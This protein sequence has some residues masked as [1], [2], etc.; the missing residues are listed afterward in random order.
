MLHYNC[1]AE[2]TA[3]KPAMLNTKWPRNLLVVA[4]HADD[5]AIGCGG[6]IA[7]AAEQGTKVTVV[8]MAAGGIRHR[9]LSE[10]CDISTRIA[11]LEACSQHLGVSQVQVL[12]KGKDMSLEAISMLE[13]VTALDHILDIGEYEEVF[14][15]QPS[16]NLDH[17]IT[18]E[19]VFTALR[20]GCRRPTPSLIALYEGTSTSW[21]PQDLPSGQLYVDITQHIQKKM[22]ALAEYRSQ[23]RQFPHPNSLEAVKTLASMRGMECGVAFAEMFRVHR[24]LR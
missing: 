12:F 1:T 7:I 19:A 6:T 15:P 14:L 2:N 10:A 21:R 20:P 3:R 23:I 17:R 22:D 16:H 24:A 4:P 5:E 13:L 18:C 11:E 9:H 8:V